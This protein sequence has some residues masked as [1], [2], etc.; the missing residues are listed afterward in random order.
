MF[1]ELAHGLLFMTKMVFQRKAL[2]LLLLGLFF[3]LG[4]SAKTVTCNVIHV[5]VSHYG[6][7]VLLDEDVASR[8]AEEQYAV[9]RY[10]TENPEVDVIGER[11]QL[12][13]TREE[14]LERAKQTGMH[15]DLEKYFADG[16]FDFYSTSSVEQKYFA[17]IGGIR[18]ALFAGLIDYAYSYV[19]GPKALKEYRQKYEEVS[20]RFGGD[21][22]QVFYAILF[23]SEVSKLV[24]DQREEAVVQKATNLCAR[25]PERDKTI[26]VVFGGSH[27]FRKY[28][29]GKA[30][31][32][33]ERLTNVGGLELATWQEMSASIEDEKAAWIHETCGQKDHCGELAQEE[34]NEVWSN[35]VGFE[36]K[37]KHL[38]QFLLLQGASGRERRSF[39]FGPNPLTEEVLQ[40]QI[41]NYLDK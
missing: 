7:E 25:D 30:G 26:V 14:F 28:F 11:V 16:K 21:T 4:A 41:K 27:D 9:V 37:Q 40:N 22:Q 34:L 1:F 3:P 36:K 24:V 15:S 5:P 38:R 32:R 23:V 6:E 18:F 10:L 12:D 2:G 31:I 29:S 33:F 39:T 19:D 13:A 17:Y 35:Y 8:V 20:R